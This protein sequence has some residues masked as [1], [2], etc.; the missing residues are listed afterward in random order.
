MPVDQGFSALATNGPAMRAV[1]EAE[2]GR[3]LAGRRLP[4]VVVVGD[5][6][7]TQTTLITNLTRPDMALPMLGALVDHMRANAG[8]IEVPAVLIPRRQ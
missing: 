1:V 4:F 2:I 3:L 8:S 5:E 6:K 7:M